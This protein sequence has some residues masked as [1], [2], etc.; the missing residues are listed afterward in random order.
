M[1]KSKSFLK[2][3]TGMWMDQSF[4]RIIILLKYKLV[5]TLG[6]NKNPSVQT[7]VKILGCQNNEQKTRSVLTIYTAHRS[8]LDEVSVLLN[9]PDVEK[10]IPCQ[11]VQPHCEKL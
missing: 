4:N 11:C 1:Q 3:H 8:N 5:K 6:Q 9:K 10:K 7:I 2:E